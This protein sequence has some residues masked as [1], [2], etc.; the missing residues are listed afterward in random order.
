MP[1]FVTIIQTGDRLTRYKVIPAPSG[2]LD[3]GYTE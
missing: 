3:E 1:F 2:S